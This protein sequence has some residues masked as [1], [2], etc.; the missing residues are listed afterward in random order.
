VQLAFLLLALLGFVECGKTAYARYVGPLPTGDGAAWVSI[1]GFINSAGEQA[2]PVT[3]E[4]MI[5]LA[6]YGIPVTL[7]SILLVF[8]R[9]I[10][11]GAPRLSGSGGLFAL[12]SLFTLL[13]YLALAAGIL[14]A[15]PFPKEARYAADAFVV[16]FPLAEFWFVTGV[17]ASG[18]A[19]QSPGT[20]RRVGFLGFVLGLTV[21][22]ALSG[23]KHIEK[24]L[25]PAMPPADLVLATQAAVG[26][27]WLLVVGAYWF[28]VRSV[29]AA[30]REFTDTVAEKA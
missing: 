4:Q 3:K 25:Q 24:E 28:A 6:C 9:L 13:A 15:T 8:G 22:V 7:A 14:F 16:A 19:L 20:A 29:R 5:D 17:T 23:W 30:A 11:S 27:A 21:A 1:D 18:L 26:G 10:A 2:I 12:S